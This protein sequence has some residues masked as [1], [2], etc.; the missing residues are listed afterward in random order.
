LIPVEDQSTSYFLRPVGI[1]DP[2]EFIATESQRI[3]FKASLSKPHQWQDAFKNR[4]LP[5]IAGCRNW[6][7]RILDDDSAKTSN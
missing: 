6:Y 7:K 3:S 1:S 4:P 2:S 5:P